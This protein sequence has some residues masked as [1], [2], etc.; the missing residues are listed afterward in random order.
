MKK[1][2]GKKR[3]KEKKRGGK[4][5][6][7]KKRNQTRKRQNVHDVVNVLHIQGGITGRNTSLS[8]HYE[9]RKHQR[10]NN[11]WFDFNTICLTSLF[12]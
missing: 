5:K 12:I 1:K 3:K 9:P 11:I 2:K 6:K 8:K 7:E 10:R 4:R